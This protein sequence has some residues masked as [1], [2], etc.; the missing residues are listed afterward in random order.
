MKLLK[1]TNFGYTQ[2]MPISEN[3]PILENATFS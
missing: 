3:R 1:S 2:I